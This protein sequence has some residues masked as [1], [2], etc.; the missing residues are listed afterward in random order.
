VRKAVTRIPEAV[1]P[2]PKRTVRVQ[3]FDDAGALVHASTSAPTA[4][5]W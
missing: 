5:T 2:E 3:A 1:Q 4:T